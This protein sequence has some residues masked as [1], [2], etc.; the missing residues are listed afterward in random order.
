MS[1]KGFYISVWIPLLLPK[2][3]R[4]YRVS[5]GEFPGESADLCHGQ[6]GSEQEAIDEAK[7]RIDEVVNG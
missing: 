5:V 7:R 4:M 1:Y 2:A 6:A 3:P